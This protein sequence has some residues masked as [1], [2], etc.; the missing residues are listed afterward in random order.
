MRLLLT[1]ILCLALGGQALFAKGPKVRRSR[2]AV[3]GSYKVKKGH[4]PKYRAPRKASSR[5]KRKQA[6]P[7][8]IWI[9]VPAAPAPAPAPA[10]AAATAAPEK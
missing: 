3:W 2:G 5:N 10:A 1:L 4:A 7:R 6:Q 9:T 8:Q